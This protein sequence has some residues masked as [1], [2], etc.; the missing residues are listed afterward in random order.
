MPHYLSDKELKRTA[1]AEIAAFP[2][3]VPTQIVSNGEFN[4]LPQTREQRQLEARITAMADTLGPRHGLTRRGVL[5]SSAG[6]AAAVLARDEVFGHVFDVRTAEA[7]T[8]GIAD[9]RKDALAGQF[10]VDAQTH[11]VRDDY[12]VQ[13]LMRFG[14]YAKEHWNPGL[15]GEDT[16]TRFKFENYVKEIFADSDT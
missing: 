8:P 5:A 15:V 1:P 13:G 10:I 12:N 9:E 4:P 6:M 7:V 16:L 14:R 11:F 2:S 3:P